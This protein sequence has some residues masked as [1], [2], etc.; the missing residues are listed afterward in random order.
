MPLQNRVTPFGEII[1]TPSRGLMMGNRGILHDAPGRLGRRR[2]RHKNW[3]ICQLEYRNRRIPLMDL[4]RYT[5]LFFLDEAVALAAGHRPCYKCRRAY[6]SRFTQCWPRESP[7]RAS[8]M[9]CILHTQRV[10]R[11]SRKQIRHAGRFERLPSGAFVAQGGDA[12]L[13]L[14]SAL[15]R[16]TPEGY[17]RFIP[18]PLGD[19]TV[20]TPPAT[21]AAIAG[22]YSPALHPSAVECQQPALC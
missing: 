15:A 13:V 2:W 16:Y 22:G 9:D 19:A 10:D 8:E 17:D 7:P 21:I 1:A 4:G 14:D 20:L 11:A 6:Y 3:I 12:W 5:A 18:R